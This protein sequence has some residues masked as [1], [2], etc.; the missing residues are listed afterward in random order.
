ME[1]PDEEDD[2]VYQ[3]W[4]VKSTKKEA[5]SD[6]PA[7]SSVTMTSLT[8]GWCKPF[9]VDWML[10]TNF[11]GFLHAQSLF[12]ATTN[13]NKPKKTFEEM[14]PP[15]YHSFHDL[16]SKENF[17][18]L[19]ERKPWDHA[20]ELI[21][22]AKSTLDCKV[23]PLNR[24]EQGQ[25]DKFLD[26]NLKSGHICESKSS[27]T[28]PFFF[29]MIKNR[30]PLSLILELINKLQGAKYFMKLNICW[31]YNNVQIKEGDEEKAAFHTNHGLFKP[32]IMFF[33]LTNSPA[34][35][36]WMMNNIFKYLISERKVMIYLDDILIF[37]KDLEEHRCIAE[38]CKFEVLEMEYLGVIISEG[39][40]QMDPVKLAGIAVADSYQEEGAS[41]VVHMLT[42]L[43]GNAKWTW[44]AVQN[45]AFQQ[46]K[47]QMAEDVI[48][49]IPNKDGKFRVE[50]DAS[51]GAICAALSTTEH[52]YKIYDKELL[53]IM[54]ALSEWQHYLMGATEDVKIWTDH[55]NL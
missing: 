13:A 52:N 24:N 15:D 22:N 28:S 39:S 49:A 51:N 45:Q 29:M 20:I 33:G 31:G 32:T 12:T 46:L 17:D 6:E 34:T 21:S 48:L 14:V 37:T 40:V 50:A 38:K 9:K 7:Q 10:C 36:Q 43:T 3:Q 11:E 53:A 30:Y 25:L 1:V 23:Y 18:E 35:F 26:E 54:L 27:F 41:I 47:E 19:P 42:Q 5:T 16:F 2:M 4:L 44:G 55:Q 8:R